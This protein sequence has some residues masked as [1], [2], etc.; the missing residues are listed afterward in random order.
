MKAYL[1]ATWLVIGSAG[2]GASLEQLKNRAAIDLECQPAS[3]AIRPIDSATRSVNGCGKQAIYVEQ[4]NHSVRPTWLLNSS[5]TPAA[6]SSAA[7][8]PESHQR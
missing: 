8:E 3:L 4:F 1:A 2:C 5:I 6:T 7:K